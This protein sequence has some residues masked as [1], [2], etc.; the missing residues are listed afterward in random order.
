MT[1][2]RQAI[3]QDT[4]YADAYS[5]LA[6]SLALMPW[7]HQVPPTQ[8]HDSVVMEDCVIRAGAVGRS[9]GAY[10]IKVE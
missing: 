9:T 7:F 8:V 1:L 10:S 6:M 5:G 3:A 2:F 4:L